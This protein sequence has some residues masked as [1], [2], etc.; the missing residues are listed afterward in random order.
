M[1]SSRNLDVSCPFLVRS[2][3]AC[4][5]SNFCFQ[6]RMSHTRSSDKNRQCSCWMILRHESVGLGRTFLNTADR[7]DDQLCSAVPYHSPMNLSRWGPARG[8]AGEVVSTPASLTRREPADRVL[9]HRQERPA[10]AS[11]TPSNV[12]FAIP[13]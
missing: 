12:A 9:E 6:S 1:C 10:D 11:P 8:E 7:Y 4:W 13:V 5:A 3:Y 2:A